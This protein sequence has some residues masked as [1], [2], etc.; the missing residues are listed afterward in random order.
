MPNKE[1]A[2]PK[3]EKDLRD[4]AAPRWKKSSTESAAPIREKCRKDTDD[5]KCTKSTTDS[6]NKEPNLAMPR[7]DRALPMRA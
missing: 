4:S 5:P 6:E 2:E 1:N 3:R 7:T